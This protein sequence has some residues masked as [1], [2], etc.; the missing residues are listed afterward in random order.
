N[1]PLLASV[2]SDADRATSLWWPLAR[3]GRST[4]GH[5]PQLT[6]HDLR[7]VNPP[8][9]SPCLAV[10]GPDFGQ[11]WHCIHVPDP[12]Q[13]ATPSISIDLP[14]QERN[15]LADLNVPHHQY[16]LTP[17]YGVSTPCLQWIF[18]VSWE[19]IPNHNDIFNSKAR[20]LTLALIQISGAVASLA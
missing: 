15:G 6:T 1:A 12:P 19:V 17:R 9:G 14:A 2:T 16:V 10:P 3:P 5:D 20:S 8:L 18:Q 11:N 13:A 7:L 4:D